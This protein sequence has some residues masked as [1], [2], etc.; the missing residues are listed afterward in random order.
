VTKSARNVET[1]RT[2]DCVIGI[3]T[4]ICLF[5]TAHSDHW[6]VHQHIRYRAQNKYTLS[7]SK[8]A[9]TVA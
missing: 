9:K 6:N 7:V 5:E 4:T 3:H 2:I 8:G 1:E